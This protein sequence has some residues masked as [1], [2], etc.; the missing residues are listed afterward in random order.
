[1]KSKI[2]KML[3]QLYVMLNTAFFSFEFFK[4]VFE[5]KIQLRDELDVVSPAEETLEIQ[6]DLRR[7]CNENYMSLLTLKP[8]EPNQQLGG[9][10]MGLQ[11]IATVGLFGECLAV[12]TSNRLYL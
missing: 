7:I 3:H 8:A 2:E 4:P 12:C 5:E 6:K 1:M 11:T 9:V 10:T